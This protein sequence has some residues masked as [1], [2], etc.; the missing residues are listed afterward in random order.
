MP[1]F[2]LTGSVPGRKGDGI[3]RAI[4]LPAAFRGVKVMGFAVELCDFFLDKKQWIIF[5]ME[6]FIT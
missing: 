3:C 4:P 2:T 1:C 6:G 5:L